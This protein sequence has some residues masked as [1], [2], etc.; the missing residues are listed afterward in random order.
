[1]STDRKPGNKAM[2][3]KHLRQAAIHHQQKTAVRQLCLFKKSIGNKHI[4]MKTEFDRRAQI[5][6]AEDFG[7]FCQIT[8][9]SH[10]FAVFHFRAAVRN[11]FQ[12]SFSRQLK[13]LLQGYPGFK[14]F[15]HRYY[16]NFS[17]NVHNLMYYA[18]FLWIKFGFCTVQPVDGTKLHVNNNIMYRTSLKA[19]TDFHFAVFFMRDNR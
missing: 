1:M 10:A 16:R 9:F 7:I 18:C 13:R 14:Q 15:K 17:A 4:L 3:H 19:V 5:V 11:Y 2:Q 12:R 6:V 8:A